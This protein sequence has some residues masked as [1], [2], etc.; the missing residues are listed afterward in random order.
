MQPTVDYHLKLQG[1]PHAQYQRIAQQVTRIGAEWISRTAAG[2][3]DV[4]KVWLHGPATP[5]FVLID[6][7]EEALETPLW[8]GRANQRAE[9]GI[10][11]LCAMRDMCVTS[12]DTELVVRS[13]LAQTDE[14][15]S[16]IGVEVNKAAVRRAG[17][18]PT[19]DS[20][21]PIIALGN[22]IE[23]LLENGPQAKI[24]A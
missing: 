13:C 8:P 20:N 15:D 17:G 23:F 6:G 14:L 9:I 7:R 2:M 11:R 22:S 10:Q 4:L 12:R 16:R 24:T 1:S 5:D 3:H 19:K 18:N 21:A